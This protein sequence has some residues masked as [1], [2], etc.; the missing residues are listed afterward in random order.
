MLIVDCEQG[1]DEWFQARLGIPTA[2]EFSNIITPA[3]G[4]Y[5]KSATTYMHKLIAETITGKEATGFMSI[6]MERGKETEA[7]ARSYYEFTQGV[8]VEQVGFIYRD[9]RKLIGCSPDG[10]LNKTKGLEIKCPSP[11]VMVNYLLNPALPSEY[12]PQLQGSMLVTGFDEWDFIAY[13]SD[14]DEQLIIT[15]KRD[16]EY[17]SKLEMYLNKFITELKTKLLKLSKE[18]EAA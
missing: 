12:I 5:S 13:H 8:E 16:R 4:D 10:I 15:V 7:E 18:Q 1:D 11:G 6:W 9:E 3:K 17:I 2:S 14:F